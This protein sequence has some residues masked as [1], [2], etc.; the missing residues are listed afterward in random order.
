MTQKTLDEIRKDLQSDLY[1]YASLKNINNRIIVPYNSKGKYLETGEEIINKL[2]N[3]LLQ[4]GAYKVCMKTTTN[5][6]P[7]EFL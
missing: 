7:F 3:E 4:D 1:K 2:Q 5:Q 6:E